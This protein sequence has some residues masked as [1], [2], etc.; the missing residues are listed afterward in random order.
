MDRNEDKRRDPPQRGRVLSE[1]EEK[2]PGTANPSVTKSVGQLRRRGWTETATVSRET[3]RLKSGRSARAQTPNPGDAGGGPCPVYAR[4]NPFPKISLEL[5]TR[6][7][8]WGSV[9]LR[10][11]RRATAWDRDRAVSTTHFSSWE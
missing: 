6:I 1:S 8:A 9:D 5:V 11:T 7:K 4:I 10:Y 2:R 3:L